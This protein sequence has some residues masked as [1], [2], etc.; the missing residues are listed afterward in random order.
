M[1][2]YRIMVQGRYATLKVECRLS[3][4]ISLSLGGYTELY[5]ICWDFFFDKSFLENVSLLNFYLFASIYPAYI[6]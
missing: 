4:V 2:W 1:E 5:A 6:T 3:L